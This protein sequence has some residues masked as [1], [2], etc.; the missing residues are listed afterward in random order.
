MAAVDYLLK[1][2]KRPMKMWQ[3]IDYAGDE[4]LIEAH[5]CFNN[6]DEGLVFRT[7]PRGEDRTYVVA[8][9]AKGGWQFYKEIM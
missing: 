1:P 7:Y 4:H 9:F 6:G 5:F 3:V 2:W 8:A